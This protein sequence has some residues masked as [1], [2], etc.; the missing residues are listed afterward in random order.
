MPLKL[1]IIEFQKALDKK[2]CI[3]LYCTVITFCNS[4]N[5]LPCFAEVGTNSICKNNVPFRRVSRGIF[6]IVG[7]QEQKEKKYCIKHCIK[8]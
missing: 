7:L 1:D 8:L 6:N 3:L 4:M 5:D 2:T